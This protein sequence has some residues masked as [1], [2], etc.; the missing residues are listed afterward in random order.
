MS[1]FTAPLVVEKVGKRLWKTYRGF[2][3]YIGEEGSG[4]FIDVPNGYVTDFASIPRVFWRF[5]PPDGEYTQAAVLH[6]YL[7]D[8]RPEGVPSK[9]A[10]HIFHEAMLVLG[11]NRF[12][13]SLM[14]RAVSL[15]GPKWA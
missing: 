1:S 4:D 12:T 7:C 3:Y 8:T 6:D 13:A 2:R 9:K 5:L 11:V 14:Y 10:H 15:F